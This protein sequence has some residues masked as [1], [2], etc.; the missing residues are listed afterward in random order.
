MGHVRSGLID[1]TPVL[2]QSCGGNGA[3]L[4]VVKYGLKRKTK[5]C[6][7]NASMKVLTW[8]II[9]DAFG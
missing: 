4:I 8:G 7:G 2:H 1:I 9:W 5:E 3:L 6:S